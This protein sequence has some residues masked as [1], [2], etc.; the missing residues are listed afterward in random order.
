[1]R[2]G[3]IVGI[4]VGGTFTD[5]IAMHR[6]GRL[7]VSK[8]ASTPDDPSTALVEALRELAGSDP[9][10][11]EVGLMF[12]GTTVATNAL[13]TGHTGRVVLLDTGFRDV[14][15][16]R[17]GTRPVLY[18]LR[19]RRPDDLVERDDRLEV[20]ERLSSLGE[21]VEPLT[22][23]EIGRVVDEAVRRNPEAVAVS[24]LFSYLR[25]EHERRVAEAVRAALPDV[26]VTASS[27]I[28]REFRE[29]P[30][31]ATA[32]V[33]AGLRPLVGRYLVRAAEGAGD[34]R[35]CAV[36]RDAIERG[37]RAGGSGR[38]GSA[39]LGAL[40]P[41][42]RR[43]RRDRAG[44][45]ARAGSD[46]LL[47]YGGHVLD[48]CL[49]HG[50]VPPTSATRIVDD[51]PVLVPSV[52]M[53]TVGAGGGSI[54]S[55][56]RAGRLRVGPDS[57]GAV[58]GPAAY[59]RGG[60]DATLTDAHVVAGILGDDPLAGRLRLDR[61]AGERAVAAVAEPLGLDL[62]AAAD[63]I[64][65]VAAAHSVRALRRV[66]VERGLD[67]RGF[68]LVAFGG[69]GPLVATRV[70]DELGLAAVVAS[71]SRAVLSSRAHGCQRADR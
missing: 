17:N 6:D 51:H 4:D 67:P 32:V 42:G 39:S 18:D 69:A 49:V 61:A 66:S 36:P 52:D 53:V 55:V 7:R 65:A 26:P 63:G 22:D 12:H 2:A 28:A 16:F 38:T 9:E 24:F 45:T 21:I 11:S 40:R 8:V 14:M 15:A 33:N 34:G 20:A 62:L 23:A 10:P 43:H 19:Q 68:T 47:R 1:M 60:D 3:W 59:G 48:V 25:D 30:R 58:P 5:A 64:I 35:G 31:T 71:S 44:G 46:H 70:M 54:A 57:A 27:E 37:L 56:D 41:D 13:I 50:G 29:Y